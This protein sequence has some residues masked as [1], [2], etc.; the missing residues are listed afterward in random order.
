M[1]RARLTLTAL[2]VVL[3]LAACT[4]APSTTPSPPPSSS[5][6]P[7][8]SPTRTAAPSST[9]DAPPVDATVAAG[10][11]LVR[12]V[13]GI[14]QLFVIDPDGSARQLTGLPGGT[15]PGAAIPKWSPDRSM[16]A[17]APP[18]RGAGL[19]PQ[20]WLVNAD[21]TD[22][23]NV[24]SVG[25]T[26]GWSPDSRQLLWMESVYT[27]DNTGL[28][29]R[30]WL[31]DV[32]AGELTDLGQGATPQWLPDGE[33]YSYQ[34]V[35]GGIQEDVP[36]LLVVRLDG[37]GEPQELAPG[38]GGWWSPDG[39]GVLLRR[40][41]GLYL[42]DASGTDARALVAGD[43]PVWSPDGQRVAYAHVDPVGTFMVGVI[44]REG[45]LVWDSVPGSNPTWSPDGTMLAVEVGIEEISTQ[46]LD[47][48]TGEVIWE[49][50]GRHPAW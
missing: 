13:D 39:T 3:L 21:G 37:S 35:H 31:Y 26:T 5:G 43:N 14:D 1:Y 49:L 47:A 33:R 28:P 15:A 25:E 10:L 4:A 18:A 34:P 46:I 11:A 24:A 41:D 27:T 44:D 17:F 45:Q 6:S 42:A 2:A 40:G 8:P 48:A 50:E 22:Q 9:P 29:P 32:A 7:L 12:P 38:A 30:L 36:T 16:I 23:R 19:D 20:L